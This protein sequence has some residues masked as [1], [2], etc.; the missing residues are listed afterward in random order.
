MGGASSRGRNDVLKPVSARTETFHVDR[1]STAGTARIA[2]AVA[3]DDAAELAG[4]GLAPAWLLD[5]LPS[6]VIVIDAVGTI[7]YANRHVCDLFGWDDRSAAGRS[8]LDVIAADDAD[9][10]GTALA[11]GPTY[12][13]NILGPM[14]VRFVEADG[15]VSF[16]ELWARELDDRSGYVLVA[17]HGS[18]VDV[19]GDAV[20]AIATGQPIERAVEL[21]V[22]GFG[23]YP[24]TGAAC[25][26]R[27]ADDGVVP[28]TE[29]P[30]ALDIVHLAGAPWQ[31]AARLGRSVDVN[32]PAELP[33]SVR[34]GLGD[35]FAG[36]L[37]CRPVIGR[38][39]EVSAVI[40][41]FR[42]YVRPP[43][44]NQTSRMAQLVNVTALA[45]DQLEYRHDARAGGVHRSVDGCC[46]AVPGCARSW[47]PAWCGTRC[48][49]STSTGSRTS[50]TYTA[51]APV[52]PCSPRSAPDCA[53]CCAASISS[54][55]SVVTSS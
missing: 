55:G 42:P 43:T 35:S 6:G 4:I 52:M 39:G 20:Q 18:V 26:L 17:P 19:I 5:A 29:W 16:A 2:R 27:V 8:V 33:A 23:M 48:C 36:S 7:R 46:D 1:P 25:V 50:T 10:V 37:W 14:R 53:A 15:R 38:R 32:D 41:V 54:C 3:S 24:M 28:M 34:R 22:A 13:G 9:T 40:V 30:F 51:T 11:E 47:T 44:A 12:F 45:F 31:I 21:L 49:T